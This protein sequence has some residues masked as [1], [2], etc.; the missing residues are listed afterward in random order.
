MGYKA[1][2]LAVK[3]MTEDAPG[4]SVEFCQTRLVIRET[5]AQARQR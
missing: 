3:M 5:T 1:V 2:S 4:S